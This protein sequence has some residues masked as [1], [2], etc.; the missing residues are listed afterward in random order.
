MANPAHAAPALQAPQP[1]N[2]LTLDELARRLDNLKIE[3]DFEKIRTNHAL[4]QQQLQLR[5]HQDKIGQHDQAIALLE[6]KKWEMLRNVS[7]AGGKVIVKIG[8]KEAVFQV[9][10][11]FSI[12]AAKKA[13]AVTAAKVIPIVSVIVGIGLGIFRV[14][15]GW[16][17]GDKTEYI[18]AAGE[19]GSGI[20]ACFPGWGTAASIAADVGMA[21]HDVYKTV[22]SSNLN[23]LGENSAQAKEMTLEEAYIGLGLQLNDTK[24]LV[25][26]HYREFSRALHPDRHADQ[27]EEFTI[28]QQFVNECR[29]KIYA[30]NKW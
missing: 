14:I 1:P 12:E 10:K 21:S 8:A 30:T 16:K 24:E 17:A 3:Q 18:K 11:L 25:D 26:R 20:L 27:Q 29:D 13:S 4:Q 7:F 5:Q 23:M 6:G 28:L 22:T 19:V 15:K 9:A 2:P